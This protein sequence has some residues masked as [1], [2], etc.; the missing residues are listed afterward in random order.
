[1]HNCAVIL[2]TELVL[3][4][5]P[6][7]TWNSVEPD[8]HITLSCTFTWVHLSRPEF[9]KEY[10]STITLLVDGTFRRRKYIFREGRRNHYLE[11]TQK[12]V[13]LRTSVMSKVLNV[14]YS[15]LNTQAIFIDFSDGKYMYKSRIKFT[16]NICSSSKHTAEPLW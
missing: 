16:S 1:M 9:L 10:L 13:N 15:I 14:G 11:S 6:G 3:S 4:R 5:F 12:W 7:L 8:V 2:G